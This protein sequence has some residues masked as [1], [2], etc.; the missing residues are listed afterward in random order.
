MTQFEGLLLYI[1]YEKIGERLGFGKDFFYNLKVKQ[2][3][4][5]IETNQK[6]VLKKLQH[7]LPLNVIFYVYDEAKWKAQSVYDFM[8]QDERFNPK[9]VV[10]KNCAVEGNANY[11]TK[12][13][14]KR[15]YEFFKKKGMN[16]E[17]GYELS[18]HPC[19]SPAGRGEDL[20]IPLE[21]FKPDIIIYSHPWYVYKTQGPVVCSKFALTFYI[22]YFIVIAEKWFEYDL[23][24]HKYLFKHYVLSEDIKQSYGSKMPNKGK[25]LEAVGHPILDYYYLHSEEK[26]KK[27]TIYAPHWTVCGNNIRFGTFDWSGYKILEFAKA[28]PELNWVFRPHP[29]FYNFIIS[30]NYMSKEELDNYYDE[31]RKIGFISEGGDYLGLFKESNAL[32]TDCGSFIMEYFVSENPMIHLVSEQ[33]EG[34]S[35]VQAV[36]KESYIARNID[37]LYEHLNTV[38]LNKN[39]YKK[40]QRIQLLQ[41]LNLKNSYSAKRIIDDILNVIGEYNGQ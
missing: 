37:E 1:D 2:N 11:Q 35:V 28:H 23:R 24:F 39:D 19:P 31:W 25:N 13:D 8:V 29:L 34:N 4:K 15:C 10:T 38:L 6:R 21:Q 7:K 36:D 16:V 41:N 9:I 30:S 32:I 12:E 18:P 26:E 3:L 17:Y 20:Y 14:V 27:Y 40:E 33:F 22:P 5:Y